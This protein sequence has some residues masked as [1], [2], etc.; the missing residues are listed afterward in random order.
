MYSGNGNGET[1][2]GVFLNPITIIFFIFLAISVA[3]SIIFFI[4]Q[5]NAC[6]D[7]KKILDINKDLHYWE[8]A[9]YESEKRR[10]IIT[11]SG[12]QATEAYIKE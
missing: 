7:I 12:L 2:N 11:E 6:S 9:R 8:R 4:K 1:I 5:W 3:I 10:G